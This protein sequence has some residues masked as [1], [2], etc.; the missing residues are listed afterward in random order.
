MNLRQTL[1]NAQQ[2]DAARPGF[3]GEHWLVLGAGLLALRAAGR[4]RGV[5]PRMVGRAV[6]S[7]LVARAA[8]GRDGVLGKL[9]GRGA[10]AAAARRMTTR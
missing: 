7:A 3:R 2:W 10:A 5:I 8:S 1:R 4:S 9:P 6:G